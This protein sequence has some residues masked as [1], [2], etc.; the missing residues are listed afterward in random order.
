MYGSQI[1][2]KSRIKSGKSRKDLYNTW[3]IIVH[4][5]TERLTIWIDALELQHVYSW[6]PFE[7][8]PPGH[9]DTCPIWKTLNRML[10]EYRV[11]Q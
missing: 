6:I 9:N 7:S 11:E 8:L 4:L 5:V 1:Q 10:C 3:T 2:K